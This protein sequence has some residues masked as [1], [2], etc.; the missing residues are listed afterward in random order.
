M[1][2]VLVFDCETI[3]L[4][5]SSDETAV[6][7]LFQQIVAIAGAWI[8]PSGVIQRLA[9]LGQPSWSEAELVREFFKIVSERHPQ[10]VGWNSGGFDLPVLVYRAMVHGIAAPAFYLHGEPYHGYRKRYDEESHIDLMD[11]LSFYGASTRA[12]LDEMALL[13]GV[14]GKLGVDGSQVAELYAAGD[15]KTIRAYCETDVLTTALVYSR[16][17][18]HRGWW[19]EAQLHSFELSLAALLDA[20]SDAQWQAFRDQ[21]RSN[22]R[23]IQESP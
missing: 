4:I 12:K 20:S 14:P 8:N 16:Y 21:W 9:A 19:D 11:V 1:P 15:L 23:G 10:L 7:P 5:E 6:K 2:H 13:L 3:P 17:A 18:I 22:P